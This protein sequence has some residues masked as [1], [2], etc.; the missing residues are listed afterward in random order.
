MYIPLNVITDYSLLSSLIKINELIK[1]AKEY[2]FK[3]IGISDDNLCYVMEFYK[4]CISNDIKPI[5]GLKVSIEGKDIYLYAKNYNGYKNLCFISS[6]EKSIDLIKNN[7]EDLFCIMPYESISL[8]DKLNIPDTY[9]GY[10]NEEEKDNKYKN[11]FFN[12][13]R[14]INEEDTEYLKYLELIKEGKTI[15]DDV[16]NYNNVHLLDKKDLNTNELSYFDEIYNM[17]D[18][19]IIKNNLLPRYSNDVNFDENKYLEELCKKGLLKRFDNKV[20]IKYADR[21]IYELSII[22]NMGFSNYFLV[23]WDYVKYAKKNNILVGP[24]RGS[25]AGSLVSYSLGITDIDPI[26]YDLYFERFLNPERVTMPDIDIDFESDRRDEVVKYVTNRYGNKKVAGIITYGTLKAKMALRDVARIF[27]MEN[28]IDSFIRLFDS[29]I[30]L[31]DNLKNKSITDIIKKD[32]LI[33]RICSISKKIEGLKRTRSSHAAGIVISNEELDRYIPLIKNDDSYITGYTM[34][35]LE[36]LGLLKM[37]FLAL[38]NLILISNLVNEIGDINLKDIPLDDKETLDIFK[39]VN[40]DGIFQF[41]S[42]GI[43]S[44][45]RKFKVTSFNDLT[46]ILALFR[47]GPMDN[48][49][50][51]IRRKEGKEKITYLH[52]DLKPILENTYGIIIYQEQIIEIATK[53]AA[54]TLGEADILRRAMSKKNNEL[55]IRQKEKFINGCIK[56]GYDKYLGEAIFNYINKFAS[57]GFNKSH[58]V[59]YALI[60][61]QMAYLKAHYKNYYMKYLLSMVIGNEIKTKQYINECKLNNINILKPDINKSSNMYIIQNNSIIF[62]LSSI[63]NVGSVIS[64]T[65]VK[66]RENGLYYDFLDFVSRTYKKGVN[67]KVLTYLIYSSCFDS[68]GLNKKT[69]INNIDLAIN[70]AELCNDLDKSLIEKPEL[71]I[72]EEY[73]K[74]DLISFEYSAFGFYLSI[75][76]VQKY[77]T[78]NMDTRK[79]KE[80]FNKT[81]VIYLLADRKK[82]IITKKQEKMLFLSASDEYSE[83]EL[84]IFP[85]MYEKFYNISRGDVFKVFGRVEKRGSEYQLIVN[86]M[87][88]L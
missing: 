14:C 80:Y 79:L 28:K 60:S 36:E 42:S 20:P 81:I 17:V 19:N 43:K 26:K 76:P 6:N 2:G 78:N 84:V 31:D 44:V 46:S 85:K 39:N 33:S 41:E 82:E 74:E 51:Y 52:Y 40:T 64:N 23:V 4:A 32:T 11:I 1:K 48:I 7:I 56:N 45:L 83:I 21:L 49:D 10:K 27:N 63:K 54:F 65:I 68:F 5:I 34:S 25:A 61:Y 73:S 72:E 29:N 53:I 24:G 67:K 8:Y 57:Y 15:S 13:V 77:R 16:T 62:S 86:N 58:S 70:Y 71:V 47:P 18:I 35:Y 38:D 3:A 22:K 30:S 50:S 66:E 55:M 87:E 37:D 59:S 88:K 12:E 69:L 75:H 9:L